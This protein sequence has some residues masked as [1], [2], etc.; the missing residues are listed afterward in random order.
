MS[1]PTCPDKHGPLHAYDSGQRE[2]AAC[3]ACHG[4]WMPRLHLLA[5]HATCSIPEE[6]RRHAGGRK[7]FDERHCPGCKSAMDLRRVQGFW[8]DECPRCHG[9]WL[10]AGEYDA[11]IAR[12]VELRRTGPPPSP[13]PNF[14]SPW[15]TG[16]DL[17]GQVLEGV[18]WLAT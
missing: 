1:A 16:L 9:V 6:S 18:I 5:D 13:P 11:V 8:V 17:V 10:D 14:A 3:E 7:R 2:L 4:L 12:L 15:L